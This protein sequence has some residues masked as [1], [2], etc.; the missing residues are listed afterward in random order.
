MTPRNI[1]G[2]LAVALVASAAIR[3]DAA[4]PVVGGTIRLNGFQPPKSMNAFVDNMRYTRMTFSFMYETLIETDSV[5][6]EFIPGLAE[7]WEMSDDAQCYTFHIDPKAK[8]SDGM[9]VTSADVKWTFDTI[10]EPSALTGP[11]KALLCDFDSPEIVDERTVRFRVHHGELHWRDLLNCGTF[12]IMPKHVFEGKDF[13]ALTLEGAVV[14]GPYVLAKVD[15]QVECVFE[16]RSDW[17]RI[18]HRKNVEGYFNFERIVIRYF[19]DDMNAYEAFKLGKLDVY[20]VYSARIMSTETRGPK[21][22]TN[23][24]RVRRVTNHTPC[25]FQGFAMNLRHPPFNDLKARQAMAMLVDRPTMNRT[26]MYNE[27]FL[28]RSYCESLYDSEHSCTNKLWE[29]DPKAAAKLLDEAGWEINPKTGI[30]EK[31]GRPFKFAFLSRSGSE[32]KFLATFS[33]ALKN[34]GVE[35][36]IVRKDLAGWMRDMD[37][38]NFDMTWSSWG[39]SIFPNFETLWSTREANRKTGNNITGFS[40]PEVD[41]LIELE[42]SEFNLEKRNEYHRRAD[43]IIASQVPYVLLWNTSST[44]LLYWNKFGMPEAPLGRF[45]IETEIPYYWWYDADAAEELR[46]EEWLPSIP[47]ETKYGIN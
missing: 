37:D 1:L 33:A 20:A 19:A 39:S 8:W 12:E 36:T 46:T 24:I 44:R 22:D 17:W 42:K 11:T 45:G 30:R 23:K 4:G 43:A 35:M 38:F 5:T 31:D 47:V 10:M 34:V 27:Y 21:Y 9:P 16:R 29:Y 40:N 14:S 13:N 3:T 41:R 2:A 7:S 28:H 26:L 32:D 25:G 18:G 6:A 15:D